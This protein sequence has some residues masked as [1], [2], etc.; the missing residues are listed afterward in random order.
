MRFVSFEKKGKKIIAVIDGK[1][2]G[3]SDSQN[4]L[5]GMKALLRDAK[6]SGV[7]ITKRE[8]SSPCMRPT[9]YDGIL[10]LTLPVDK[11]TVSSLTSV[12]ETT[13]KNEAADIISEALGKAKDLTQRFGRKKSRILKKALTQNKLMPVTHKL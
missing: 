5:V 4:G 6:F 1:R 9:E 11:K 2:S 3:I 10:H 8:V 12:Y 7:K 13:V